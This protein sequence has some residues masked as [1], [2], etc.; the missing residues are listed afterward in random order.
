MRATY[1]TIMEGKAFENFV[2]IE[3]CEQ[4]DL[5]VCGGGTAGVSAA[6]TARD[7]GLQTAIVEDKTALGGTS[8][9]GGVWPYYFGRKCGGVTSRDEKAKKLFQTGNFVGLSVASFDEG[10]RTRFSGAITEIANESILK[11][12]NCKVYLDSRVTGVFVQGNQIIGVEYLKDGELYSIG[13]KVV[14]DC[15][16]GYVSKL[17]GCRLL[18]GRESDNKNMIFSR[19]IAKAD[20]EKMSG[21]AAHCG[22]FNGEKGE[23]EE[24]VLSSAIKAPCLKEQYHAENRIV[25][26]S[27]MLGERSVNRVETKEVSTL[28]DWFLEN[29]EGCAYT[30]FSHLDNAYTDFYNEDKLLVLWNFIINAHAIGIDFGVKLGSLM[31]ADYANLFLAGK[32]IGVDYS[33]VG[34]IRMKSDIE[35]CGE[36][37]AILSKCYLENGKV[38]YELIKEQLFKRNLISE[39]TDKKIYNLNFFDGENYDCK[40]VPK[41]KDEIITSLC[42]EYQEYGYIGALAYSDK[43]ELA[44]YLLENINGECACIKEEIAITLA[45]LKREESLPLL[46]EIISREAKVRIRKDDALNAYPWLKFTV[47]CNFAKALALLCDFADT[48]SRDRVEEIYADGANAVTTNLPAGHK[49]NYKKLILGFAEKYLQAIGNNK[50]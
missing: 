17:A 47:H 23:F 42:G 50:K 16:D 8:T 3:F 10:R 11:E 12:K 5:I 46:R 14:L 19:Y 2:E 24:K 48:M 39:T 49:E 29:G 37:C 6:I 44:R 9:L 31:S 21:E 20:G 18:G 33:S 41:T 13:C 40:S 7:L 22:A 45:L 35:R 34:F 1:K 28:N 30:A 25:F 4:F 26:H 15:A 32:H 38:A 43:D 27:T 36:T